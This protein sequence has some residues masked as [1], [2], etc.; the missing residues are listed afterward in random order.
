M[1]GDL[2]FVWKRWTVKP[3]YNRKC[4]KTH[5]GFAKSGFFLF[6]IFPLFVKYDTYKEVV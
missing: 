4:N 5:S 1:E 6:G 3:T 2:M